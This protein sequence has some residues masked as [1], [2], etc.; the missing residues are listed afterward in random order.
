MLRALYLSA[1]DY[2]KR[3]SALTL[4]SNQAED[5]RMPMG[6]SRTRNRSYEEVEGPKKQWV[7]PKEE[8]VA[9]HL[10]RK[11][12]GMP[13]SD[14]PI[15]AS[16]PFTA[17]RP[18]GNDKILRCTTPVE[19]DTNGDIPS[20]SS[21]GPPIPSSSQTTGTPRHRRKLRSFTKLP[22]AMLTD[23]L[24]RVYAQKHI[25][26]FCSGDDDDGV[27]GD[28]KDA[29]GTEVITISDDEGER[30]PRAT[31]SKRLPRDPPA[32]TM[33]YLSRVTDLRGFAFRLVRLIIE[34]RERKEA[35]EARRRAAKSSLSS[36]SARIV[37]RSYVGREKEKQKVEQLFAWAIRAMVADG[38]IVVARRGSLIW[39]PLNGEKPRRTADKFRFG[40]LNWS[41]DEDSDSS[42]LESESSS[43]SPTPRKKAASHQTRR[44]HSRR[45]TSADEVEA[46]QL[47]TPRLLAEPLS[48]LQQRISTTD[49]DLLTSL[50]RSS[51]ERWRRISETSVEDALPFALQYRHH[52]H[53]RAI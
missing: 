47:V 7:L 19:A 18:A 39:A 32:F 34:K 49:I 46:Y 27:D 17:P 42:S 33:A 22:D 25:V 28:S 36:S 12:L 14:N 48:S 11:R 26:D 9:Q 4:E 24:F 16:A 8:I 44:G 30:T 10:S 52:C 43:G 23:A 45:T 51:D 13:K 2:S 31:F 29:K 35:R 50:L 20:P 5:T 41:E 53:H 1:T 6:D 21:S 38:V 15:A 37:K 40:Q 3:P